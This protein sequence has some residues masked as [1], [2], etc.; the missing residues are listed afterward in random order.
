MHYIGP[1]AVIVASLVALSGF[2][3]AKKPEMKATF[4]KIQP[5]QGFLGVGLLFF[6]L[7][8]FYHY[9]FAT[10]IGDMSWFSLVM[11]FD[12]VLGIAMI[13]YIASE[14]LLGFILGFGLIASW[15]PGEGTA[16][17]KGVAVQKK[18]LAFSLPIGIVGIVS[19]L[20]FLVKWKGG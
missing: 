20:L 13:G 5:Y 16:E 1:L 8:D 18:L 15:I 10:A 2:I 19:A 9:F 7:Y 11:K 17:K 6:G 4:E 3:I 14:I 12:K